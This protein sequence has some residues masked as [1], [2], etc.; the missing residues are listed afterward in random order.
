MPDTQYVITKIK[1][2][3]VKKCAVPKKVIVKKDVKF[4]GAAKK[5]L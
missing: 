4:K 1:N 3:A 2:P 5:W